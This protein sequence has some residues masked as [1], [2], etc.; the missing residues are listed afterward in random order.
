MNKRTRYLF[1]VFIFISPMLFNFTTVVSAQSNESYGGNTQF[2]KLAVKE[3]DP[4]EE[5]R[6][7]PTRIRLVDL[8]RDGKSEVVLLNNVEIA[9]KLFKNVRSYK[10]GWIASLGWDGV[11]FAPLWKT[12]KMTGRLQD[13]AIG[14]FD[15]DGRQE[16][17]I[18]LVSKEGRVVGTTPK[19]TII[20]YELNQ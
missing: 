10:A 20:A 2:F 3:S 7:L 15:S 19:S 12:R 17:L 16:L 5:R 11:G 9:D 14:D 18:V 8:D 4:M 13:F 6:Y 1:I